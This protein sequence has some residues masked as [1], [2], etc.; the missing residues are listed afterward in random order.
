MTLSNDKTSCT[1]LRPSVAIFV[2]KKR[3]CQHGGLAYA[4]T[5]GKPNFYFLF[6]HSLTYQS[7]Y[8]NLNANWSTNFKFTML[9]SNVVSLSL[10]V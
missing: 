5:F 7:N 10:L 4:K 1:F 8:P 9:S 6:P 3:A 2:C